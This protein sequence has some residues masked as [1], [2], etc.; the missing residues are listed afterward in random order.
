MLTRTIIFA[1]DS[2]SIISVYFSNLSRL[3]FH[4]FPSEKNRSTFHLH[5]QLCLHLVDILKLLF[6]Q[7]IDLEYH[8]KEQWGSKLF[9]HCRNKK[10]TARRVSNRVLYKCCNLIFYKSRQ[11]SWWTFLSGF[12]SAKNH[13][14]RNENVFH[15]TNVVLLLLIKPHRDIVVICRHVVQFKIQRFKIENEQVHF[16]QTFLKLVSVSMFFLLIYKTT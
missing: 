8:S 14:Q 4:L 15:K 9:F 1:K 6:R 5:F 10:N 16:G 11:F 2:T 7:I 13:Q 12:T 3:I